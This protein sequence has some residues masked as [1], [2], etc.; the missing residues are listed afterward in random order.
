M[1]SQYAPF[2]RE[3]PTSCKTAKARRA[4][5]H[6]TFMMT[7]INDVLSSREADAARVREL[8]LSYSVS[9]DQII[10]SALSTQPPK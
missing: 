10:Y 6:E 5:A 1:R 3:A 8:L 7:M 9:V 4:I 2:K